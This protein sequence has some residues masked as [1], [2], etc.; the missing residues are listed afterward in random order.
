MGADQ[1]QQAQITTTGIDHVGL[2]VLDVEVARR[3]FCECLGW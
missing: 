1:T 2:T 3:F